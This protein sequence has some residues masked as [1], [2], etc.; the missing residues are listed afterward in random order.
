MANTHQVPLVR[1][2]VVR[3]PM[4]VICKEIPAHEVFVLM[5]MFPEVEVL[6][7]VLDAR[8]RQ[9]TQTVDAFA[10]Y[11][12]L[13]ACYGTNGD[14]DVP[15]VTEA[16]GP[17][18]SS[19]WRDALKGGLDLF[20][21]AGDDESEPVKRSN[22][23]QARLKDALKGHIQQMMLQ[24]PERVRDDWWVNDGRPE[25]SELRRRLGGRRVSAA[26]RDA[27]Y[28]EI[29][30][31]LSPDEGSGINAGAVMARLDDIDVEY[32]PDASPDTLMALLHEHTVSQI[33][34]LGGDIDETAGI[35]ALSTQ[36]D[37]L[38]AQQG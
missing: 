6:G 4:C 21:M 34:A 31:E 18:H 3:D 30:A 14:S 28:A 22:E 36:L 5:S 35:E 37:E 20:D 11:E 38:R 26:E 10:E 32:D 8:G 17:Q 23:P 25:V 16:F 7:P 2:K 15:R 24:D 19:A 1:T 27:A 29:R 13:A 12:R 9:V 33:Q